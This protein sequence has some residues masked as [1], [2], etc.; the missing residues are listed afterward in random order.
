MKNA[1]LH[2]L[3]ALALCVCGCLT[4]GAAHA[5]EALAKKYGCTGCHAVAEKIVGPAFVEI[6]KRYGAENNA[7]ATIAQSIQKGGVGKWGKI[8]MP[9]NENVPGV[10]AKVLAAWILATPK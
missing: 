4:V 6:G 5:N 9:P 8:P 10:D 3:I 2:T 1:K 7:Q